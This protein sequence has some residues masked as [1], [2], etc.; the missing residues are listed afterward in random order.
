[1]SLFPPSCLSCFLFVHQARLL[2]SI[3][4][5]LVAS[6]MAEAKSTRTL[7]DITLPTGG[8]F[9]S[10]LFTVP[11]TTQNTGVRVNLPQPN[12]QQRPS[13]CADL[14]VINTLDG[15]NLQPRLT[16]PFDGP[17]TLAT[18]NSDSVFLIRLGDTLPGG[19]TDT[20]KIGINQVVFDSASNVLSVES[21]ELLEQ[22][23]RYALIVTDEVRDVDGNRVKA[24]KT[25]ARYRDKTNA[26][27][28]QSAA[29]QDY[30]QK[31]HAAL[32]AAK[33]FGL[34]RKDIVAASVFTTQSTTAVLEKIRAQL[35]A[36][37][38]TP[39]EFHLGPQGALTVFPLSSVTGITFNRQTGTGPTFQSVPVP[40]I[41]LGIVPGA[42]GQ[43]AF[44]KYSSPDYET[45]EKF[46]PAIGTLSGTPAVQSTNDIFFTLF[47][48]AS[49]KPANGWPVAIFGHG[50]G[51]YN[52]NSPYAVAAGMA[53]AGIATVAINVVGHGGGP[54]GTLTVNRAGADAVTVPAGGR[55]IDQDGNQTID[56]VEGS[57]AALSQEIIASRDGLRQT[58]IDLMQ[59]VRV[60]KRG[61]DIDADGLADLDAGRI[62]YFG[63]SF[64]G[65]YGTIFLAVEP[66]AVAGNNLPQ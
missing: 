54:L 50:F 31:L 61:V 46:I 25:F 28:G 9:P 36:A 4:V 60:I 29:I 14:T 6:G 19:A 53:A 39:A 3:V 7:F 49:P 40:V 63:Q 2:L 42:V 8:P 37:T 1:V 23:A 33:T 59:L 24:A 55:G 27:Q 5:A 22:H 52:N 15:F 18:V 10:N 11:D 26:S 57:S 17:L 48:P 16:I 34:K 45:P 21:D 64:G 35:D 62:Y 20:K 44:G 66:K 65:I 43:I 13:D 41:A 38:P 51:D 56:A 32:A 47:L 12:C 58:V 30:H